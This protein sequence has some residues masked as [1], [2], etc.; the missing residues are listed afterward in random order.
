MTMMELLTE[1]Q[2]HSVLAG[3]TVDR[4]EAME[5]MMLEQP[6]VEVP[7]D[8]QFINGM[9]AREILIPEGTLLTGAVHKDAH[10]AIMLSGDIAL[11]TP[12]GVQ[13]MTGSH[14]MEGKPGWKRAAYAFEDTR[15]LTV[16]RTDHY[17]EGEMLDMLTFP[18]TGQY[19]EFVRN[20]DHAS[21]LSVIEAFG[22]TE[23]EVQVMVQN[24]SDQVDLP[25]HYG[26]R[27]TVSPSYIHGNGLQS[28]RDFEMGET[29]GPARTAEG[30]RTIIG[31]YSNHSA[32]PNAIM[33]LAEDN[34]VWMVAT[35]QINVS[36]EITTHYGITLQSVQGVLCHQ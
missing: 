8:E 28:C 35:R 2:V 26:D 10:F 18:T 4:I 13:R 30:D 16:H 7:V 36:D 5:A 22:M 14:V 15:W 34:S 29:V 33:E 6:Q 25:T 9:Y 23:G 1:E 24:E 11:A 17:E 20:R 27:V 21:Y 3:Q 19:R 32:N 31:R 12:N